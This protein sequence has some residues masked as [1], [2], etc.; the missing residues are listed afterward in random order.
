MERNPDQFWNPYLAGVALGLVNGYFI[1]GSVWYYM[2][3][4]GYPL[5]YVTPPTDAAFV[6]IGGFGVSG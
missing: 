3:R 5:T 6:G 1:A 4:S 2:D